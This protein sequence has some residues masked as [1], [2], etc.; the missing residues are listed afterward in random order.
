[1]IKSIA[2]VVLSASFVF[3]C[4]ESDVETQ[5]EMIDSTAINENPAQ[6]VVDSVEFSEIAADKMISH[7]DP[8]EMASI[9]DFLRRV[10]APEQYYL[11]TW[12]AVEYPKI[13]QNANGD[14]SQLYQA[15]EITF[16]HA[17]TIGKQL[18]DEQGMDADDLKRSFENQ[19]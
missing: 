16:D 10:T 6:V 3:G 2:A 9:E 8:M 4:G 13:Y 1:M 14:D 5:S 19:R 15:F 11:R 17:S 12:M 7:I 18:A